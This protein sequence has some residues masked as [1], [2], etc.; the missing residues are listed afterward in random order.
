MF[1]AL[2]LCMDFNIPYKTTG[3][4]TAPGW[5][6]VCCPFCHDKNF[7]GGINIMGTYYHCWKCRHSFLDKL[8]MELRQCNYFE[9]KKII[10]QYSNRSILKEDLEKEKF[11]NENV[12]LPGGKLQPIHKKYLKDRNFDP[13]FLERKYN[14]KGTTHLGDYKFRIIAPIYYQRKL[15]SYQGRDITNKSTLRYKACKKSLEVIDHK[16]VVYAIDLVPGESVIVVEGITD[17]WRI[18]PGAVATFGTSF[19]GSQMKLLAKKFENIFILFDNE[20][21]AQELALKLGTYI[22]AIQG[23]HVEIVT[24]LKSDPGELSHTEAN[25][26]KKFLKII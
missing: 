13:D 10:E 9:A 5:I 16:K 22:S 6:N 19:T 11:Q 2:Q 20:E 23:K 14:L 12:I 26:I 24:G 15:V 4:N 7:H 3:K 17:A 21:A 8:I 25:Y 18:G 1:N